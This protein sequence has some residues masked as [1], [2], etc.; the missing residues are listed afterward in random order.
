VDGS[1]H[2]AE[3]VESMCGVSGGRAATG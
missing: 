1:P 2:A 3:P